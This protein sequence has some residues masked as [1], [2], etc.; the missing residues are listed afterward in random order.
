MAGD[1]QPQCQSSE[2]GRIHGGRQG[3]LYTLPLDNPVETTIEGEGLLLWMDGEP[4]E[5]SITSTSP[6]NRKPNHLAHRQDMV[7]ADE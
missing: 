3:E 4:E 1:L 6:T 2:F 5:G 7:V